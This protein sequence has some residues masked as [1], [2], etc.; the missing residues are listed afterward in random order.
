GSDAGGGVEEAGEPAVERVAQRRGADRGHRQLE[1][2]P[3]REVHGGEPGAQREDGDGVG[4]QPHACAVL[5]GGHLTL[6]GSSA[7]TVSPP[8]V[9]C[10]GAT[11]TRDPGGRETSTRDPKRISPNVSPAATSSPGAM[12]QTMRR[13]S[14]PAIWTTPMRVPSVVSNSTALRSL[15]SLALSRSAD[16]K[17]PGR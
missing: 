13:A 8:I 15:S 4:Q 1:P 11:A 3:E 7:S 6:L 12:S 14:S 2:A 5:G 10:P 9:R 16:R 17:V